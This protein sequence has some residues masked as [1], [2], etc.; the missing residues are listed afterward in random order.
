[1]RVIILGCG[2]LGYN[3]Y[4]LLKERYS[5]ELWGIESPYSFLVREQVMV[6]A[7][8][9]V[10]MAKQDLSDAIVIDAI[11]LIP[12]SAKADNEEEAIGKLMDSYQKLIDALKH[13]NAHRFIYFSS[14]GTIYGNTT[15][16]IKEEDPID[17]MSLYARSK[18]RAEQLIRDSGLSYLILRLSNPYGGY[19][20]A[21]KKQGV[22]PILI[23]KALCHEVFEMFVETSSVRDYF[24]ITDLSRAITGLIDAD[25][26]DETINIGSGTG[27]SLRELISLIEEETGEA[28]R[29]SLKNSDVP[30]VQS[31]VLDISKLKN[32]TGVLPKVS[33]REGIHLETERI[34]KELKQ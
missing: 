20:V 34:R 13:G 1:M 26:S 33:L 27:T 23:R 8:D 18:A 4:E 7:F 12:N 24:Y 29:I 28:I 11:G 6:D 16:P 9:P 3:L 10:A 15:H 32:I 17:P 21:E 22:I 14:G 19:Q 31:I 30:V 5:T 2:Y 25:V